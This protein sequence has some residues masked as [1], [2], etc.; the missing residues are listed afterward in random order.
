MD[1]AQYAE[2]F[3]TESREHVS[4]I[5]LALLDIERGLTAA[6]QPGSGEGTANSS[7]PSRSDDGVASAVASLFRAVHTIKGMSATLR[8]DAVA[9]LSHEF[10]ALLDRLRRGELAPDSRPHE[11]SV[12]GSGSAR[13]VDRAGRGGPAG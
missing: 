3:L 8:Y 10:E 13:G 6:N 2:L 12:C 7:D 9:A 4:V 1:A 5:N 11:R